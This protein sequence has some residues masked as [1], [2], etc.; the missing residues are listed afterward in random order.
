MESSCGCDWPDLQV[1]QT[2]PMNG[3]LIGCDAVYRNLGIPGDV[4]QLD[5][6]LDY[7]KG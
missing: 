7:F 3:G 4:A 6:S 1:D 2:V 5:Q